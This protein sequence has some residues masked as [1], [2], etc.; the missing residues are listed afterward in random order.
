VSDSVVLSTLVDG[1]IVV[2]SAQT[3]KTLVRD[4]CGRLMYVGSKMLGVVL[5]KVDPKRGREHLR[6][7]GSY[8]Y[9]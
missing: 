4:A 7:Y 2:A 5:T 9:H 3:A 1:V 6:Y 8:R